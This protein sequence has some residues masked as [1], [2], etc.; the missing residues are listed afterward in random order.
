MMVRR[1]LSG[2]HGCIG[3]INNLSDSCQGR[4]ASGGRL[5][6]MDISDNIPNQVSDSLFHQ[7]LG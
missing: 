4:D 5:S 2:G 6:T 1:L 7:F 3:V